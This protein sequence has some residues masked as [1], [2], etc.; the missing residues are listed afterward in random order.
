M[1]KFNMVERHRKRHCNN[2]KGDD[3]EIEIEMKRFRGVEKHKSKRYLGIFANEKT[4]VKY[5]VS[6]LI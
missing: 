5:D 6:E 4:T 2:D 1:T 3:P